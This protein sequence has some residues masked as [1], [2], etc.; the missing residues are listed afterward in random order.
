M[1]ENPGAGFFLD[2]GECKTLFGRLKRN[3]DGL[4]HEERK[5]LL[6]LEQLLYSELTVQEVEELF[7]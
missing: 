4:S 6:R 2:L 3:E 5:I 1:E 7:C